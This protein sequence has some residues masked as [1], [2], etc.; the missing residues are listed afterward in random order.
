MPMNIKL[1]MNTGFNDEN[2]PDSIE[3]LKTGGFNYLQ[4]DNYN[5]IQ[6]DWLAEVIVKDITS[7][8]ARTVDYVVIESET[9]SVYEKSCYTVDSFEMKTR[10][11]C[12]FN[13]VLDAY[14]TLGGFDLNSGNLILSGSV[15]RCHVSLEED[16][17]KFFVLDE[18]F[19]PHER[20]NYSIENLAPLNNFT[21]K[22]VESV[23]I[24]PMTVKGTPVMETGGTAKFLGGAFQ[25]RSGGGVGATTMQLTQKI[26]G[27]KDQ[28][29]LIYTRATMPQGR[30]MKATK[31][32]I[33]R[34]DGGT[35]NLDLGSRLWDFDK[36]SYE[37]T[38]P[39]DDTK[40]IKGDLI[41]DARDTG[42]DDDIV[43][44]YEVPDLYYDGLNEDTNKQ[45]RP[46]VE[47]WGDSNDIGGISVIRNKLT[48]QTKTFTPPTQV[49][50]NKC[51]YSQ[52]CTAMVYN[53]CSG[54]NMTKKLYEI[55]NS[56]DTPA[57]NIVADFIITG[58][59]RNGGTPLFIWKFHNGFNQTSYV[60]EF[61]KGAPW[62]NLTLVAEGLKGEYEIR[63]KEG[64]QQAGNIGQ[65]WAGA[66]A[67]VA[68]AGISGALIGSAAPVV[69]NAIG[70]AVGVIGASIKGGIEVYNAYR[71]NS[72]RAKELNS[73]SI[74]ASAQLNIASSDV[75][76]DMGY[77]TFF[78][79]YTQ[80]SEQDMKDYDTFLTKYGYNMGNKPITNNDF[81]NRPAFNYI[82]VNDITIESVTGSLSL[83]N[84][85]KAQLKAGVRI[86]HRKPNAADMLA[87][88]NRV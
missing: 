8:Q 82:K 62:R 42:R 12:K 25:F 35:K 74:M 76:R 83:I 44:F 24:P 57:T 14:N 31:Y 45:Y 55:A 10:H 67:G 47:D 60:P 6:S 26:E 36:I 63:R 43:A 51:R 52:S 41:K 37:L 46:E 75:A 71:Q 80:Y 53:P 78:L 32:N 33:Y 4:F 34:F 38:N 28:T 72:D 54:D 59:I 64:L 69:G 23:T 21:K 70:A 16:N 5:L 3:L 50:N 39:D 7:R 56:W 30:P 22:F 88:G 2:I 20:C 13:L 15:E 27:G 79:V 65:A 1:Y 87:S 68:G 73:Q 18:P 85:T 61:I 19:A 81:H 86:W 9:D 66:A 48:Q 40:T 84:L 11:T 29:S 58:D 17:S 77:N 49:Y